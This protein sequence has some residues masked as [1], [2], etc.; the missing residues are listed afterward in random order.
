[1]YNKAFHKEDITK[2]RFL[3]TG[4]AGFIGSNLVEYLLKYGAKKV[5]I[6]DNLATGSMENIE[7]FTRNEAFEFV[8]GDIS[9][10]QTCVDACKEIDYVLHQAALGSVPRSVNDPLASN[11]ANVTGFLNMLVAAKENNIKRLVYA[12]SSSVYGDSPHLPKIEDQIGTPLSP[13]AVTKRVDEL[14]AG[15]F[16]K[17]YGMEIIGLRYF[18][19]FGPRQSPKGPYAAA[20]P[21]FMTAVLSNQRPF[22]NG[23]GEQSRDF[24]FVEN[25]VEANIKSLFCPINE[26]N[27]GVFNIAVGDRT[28]V[29]QLYD[30]IRESAGNSL[31]PEYRNERPGDV[32][33]SLADI[34]KAVAI[35]DY[36][37]SVKIRQGLDITFQWFKKKYFPHLN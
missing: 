32:K 17:T 15:V 11:M 31:E 21:Q 13:Y 37:P 7:P 35:M 33:H 8:L 22:I 23:D 25:A 4:G 27:G 18:N 28:T 12:S 9:E 29:N 5:R 10:P 26:C 30:F 3:V 20:I 34:G 1:M 16:A 24:T 14:Y 19:I 36:Q 6:L 2:Y